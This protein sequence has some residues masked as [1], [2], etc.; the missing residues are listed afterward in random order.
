MASKTRDSL[1]L[2][3]KNDIF[4]F[5]KILV[6][7][8]ALGRK[9]VVALVKCPHTRHSHHRDLHRLDPYRRV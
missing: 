5:P 1:R 3:Q 2:L 6:K 9:R 4:I 7:E 8:S